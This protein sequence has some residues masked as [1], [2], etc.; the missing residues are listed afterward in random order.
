MSV[1]VGH[2]GVSLEELQLAT[3]NHGMPLEALRYDI[4]PIGLHYLLIHFDIPAAEESTWRLEVTGRVRR[5]LSLGL[6]DVRSRPAVSL[7][8]TMECAGNG[9]VGMSPRPVSQPWMSE[10]VGTALWTGTPLRGVLE[11]VGIE[12][13]G[14]EVVFTGGDHGV[15]GGI[16][17]D[18]ARG[19]PLQECLRDE[20]LLAYEVN[21]QPLPPQHGFPLRLVVPGR[22]GMASVKWLRSIEVV[23]EPFQG[24]QNVQAYRMRN[25]PEEEGVPLS[26]MAPRALMI[27]P[28]FPEFMSRGRTVPL[29]P[30]QLKGRAWSGHAPIESVQVSLD[31]GQS[32]QPAE[33]GRPQA[34]TSW[35]PW[36]LQWS[37]EAPGTYELVCR[38]RDAAGNQQPLEPT[39]N[40]GGYAN[41]AV[42]R[43]SVTVA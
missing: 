29:G 5:P 25:S 41:N 13:E 38:A 20:V 26:R 23:A 7:P 4:T 40:V 22:Y 33:L 32:W 37:P 34:A 30:C 3:R 16:E 21:G 8:V 2:Q 42:Q 12:D 11:E 17:Q 43:L 35:S 10:A 27:P 31:G 18:Y 6:A 15:D 36:G 39:W 9:R 1:G 19:L 24:Y 14:L 28:G